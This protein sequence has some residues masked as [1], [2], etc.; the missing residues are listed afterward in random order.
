MNR[1]ALTLRDLVLDNNCMAL[2]PICEIVDPR[3]MY[4]FMTTVNLSPFAVATSV[5]SVRRGDVEA[6]CL[7]LP[8]LSEQ[9]RIVSKLDSLFARSKVARDE[10]ARVPLLIDH[11]K[12]A[13]LQAAFSGNLTLDWRGDRARVE[14]EEVHLGAVASGFSYGSAAKSL[15]EGRVPVLRM[16]NIQDGRLDWSDLVYTSDQH[17]IQKY[18]LTKGDVL[19]NRTNSP[20]FVGKS[21]LYSGERPAIYAGYLIRVRCDKRLD[22]RYLT[23]CLNSPQGRDYCWRVKTD[24]VSQSNI[25]AKKLA[26]FSFLL[27]ELDEQ[28]EIVRRIEVALDWLNIVGTEQGKVS[29]LLDHLDQGILAKAFRG[30]LVPQ[31]PTN[32]EPAGKLLEHV[33]AER[34]AGSRASGR[35]GRGRQRKPTE[36]AA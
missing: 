20:A 6:I 35:R 11:Y 1:R 16:G 15:P 32:D 34:A 13:I 30:E 25:N 18:T 12:K 29:D 17:G 3:Y 10:L 14:P 5:P 28:I 7:P 4:R 22:P 8:P 23:Y 24:G 33:R 21:A 2:S 26:A 19:F 27:P 31:D 36:A 9:G